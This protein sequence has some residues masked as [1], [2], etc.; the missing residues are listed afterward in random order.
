[1]SVDELSSMPRKI[2]IVELS[3]SNQK[4]LIMK[5]VRPTT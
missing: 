1:V 2:G 4:K 5:Q 3:K